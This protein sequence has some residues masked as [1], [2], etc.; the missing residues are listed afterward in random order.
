MKKMLNWIDEKSDLLFDKISHRA[1]SKKWGSLIKNAC[2]KHYVKE[3]LF[4]E[5]YQSI[6]K[7]VLEEVNCPKLNKANLSQN[8]HFHQ[9]IRQRVYDLNRE[10]I[11]LVNGEFHNSLYAL[12]R[13]MVE[14]YLLLVYCRQDNQKI[15]NLL[16]EEKQNANLYSV[17]DGLKKG[18][19]SIPYVQNIESD[20]FIESV[21]SWYRHF[22]NFYHTSGSSLSQAMWVV[23]KDSPITSRY[24]ENPVLSNGDKLMVFTKKLPID[25]DQYRILMHQ[26]YTFSDGCLKENRFIET[27][28][29]KNE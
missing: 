7:E 9:V 18:K 17:I 5:M 27:G 1:E 19:I 12:T 2:K 16:Q 3:I 23:K 24:V 15:K 29:W 22:S 21:Y 11:L 6:Q 26:F 4:L 20:K 14:L 10:F 8:Q 28:D 25:S 13:Q